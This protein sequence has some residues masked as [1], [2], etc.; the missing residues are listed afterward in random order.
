MRAS[1]DKYFMELAHVV[2]TRATCDRKHVGAILVRENIILSTGYNGSI[3]GM[4]HCDDVGHEMEND[5]CVRTVHAETNAIAQAARNGVRVGGATLYVTASPCWGCFKLVVNAG[6][7][8][9]VFLE[10]Y[11]DE[12]I[13]KAATELGIELI[14]ID[15]SRSEIKASD[16]SDRHDAEAVDDFGFPK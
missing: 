13:F 8:R 10:F 15:K 4:S 7:C 3:R 12:R 16:R 5:H 9:V 2:A 11:R 6:C 1:W 14:H